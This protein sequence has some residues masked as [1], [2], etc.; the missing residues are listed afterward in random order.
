MYSVV[1]LIQIYKSTQLKARKFV[2]YSDIH[3]IR[4]CSY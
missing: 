1:H 3:L 2:Y 4:I